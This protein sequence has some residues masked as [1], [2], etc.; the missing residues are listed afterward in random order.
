[1]RLVSGLIVIILINII[2]KHLFGSGGSVRD[3]KQ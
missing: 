2:N 1:M 3:V